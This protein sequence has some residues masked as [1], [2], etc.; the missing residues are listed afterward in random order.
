[1]LKGYC[2]V[3]LGQ[4]EFGMK[5]LKYG[6]DGFNVNGIFEESHYCLSK[7]YLEYFPRRK[8]QMSIE[9]YEDYNRS[10]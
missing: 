3:K 10:N 6:E 7:Y 5:Q 1:M 4:K 9:I 2:L 8:D